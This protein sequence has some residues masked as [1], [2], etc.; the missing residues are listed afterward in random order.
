MNRAY[1]KNPNRWTINHVPVRQERHI[2]WIAVMG[3]ITLIVVSI[4]F[5]MLLRTI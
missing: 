1:Y 2:D 5:A 4:W 3:F